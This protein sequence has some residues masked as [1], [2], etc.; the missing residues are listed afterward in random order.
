MIYAIVK[1]NGITSMSINFLAGP[2]TTTLVQIGARLSLCM[3]P[4]SENLTEVDCTNDLY[5]CA[6]LTG[7][8]YGNALRFF[9]FFFFFNI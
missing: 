1:G 9:F 3:R 6:A 5:K 8:V 4:I 2:D 7:T